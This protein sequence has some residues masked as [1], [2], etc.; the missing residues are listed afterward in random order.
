MLFLFLINWVYVALPRKNIYIS[1]QSRSLKSLIDNGGC[2]SHAGAKFTTPDLDSFVFH[3]SL[4]KTV[5]VDAPNL[6]GANLIVHGLY[7]SKMW[8]FQE[9]LIDFLS[10]LHANLVLCFP[11]CIKEEVFTHSEFVFC[12]GYLSEINPSFKISCGFVL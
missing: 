3:C 10:C 11:C 9:Y 7:L 2:F 4:K 8:F 1:I 5:L 12:F 6:L